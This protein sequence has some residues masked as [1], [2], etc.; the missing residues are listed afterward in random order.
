MKPFVL[1]TI[2]VL[3]L[4]S[5][6]SKT[7]EATIAKNS[8]PAAE[9]NLRDAIALHPD[10]V[11]LTENLIQYFR[12]N[13]NYSAA[14]AEIDKVIVKDSSNGRSWYIKATLLAENGDTAKAIPAWEKVVFFNPLPE[15]VI[16]LGTI[17]ALTRNP[18]ALVMADGLLESS[19]ANA[20]T[21]AY[22]IKGIYYSAINKKQE[23]IAALNT[24]LQIDYTNTLA[25]RE[26]AICLYDLQQ[27]VEALKVLELSAAINKKNEEIYFWMG[28]CFE[29]L[30]KK[31]EAI[32]NYQLALAIAPDYIEAKDALGKLGITN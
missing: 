15:N 12:D 14:I 5:C 31:E 30:A 24:S 25:Y 28:K 2:V 29:K 7:E 8:M 26:K 18:N 6:Q 32:Q 16:T 19:K 13:G 27:Y 20:Q 21:Q 23:A 1:I 11:L 22:L 10:S 9:K 17:Y 3:L 4:G